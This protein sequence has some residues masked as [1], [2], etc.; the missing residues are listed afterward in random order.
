MKRLKRN[1]GM[2]KRHV[3]IINRKEI[4]GA[5]NRYITDKLFESRILE[6]PQQAMQR[7]SLTPDIPLSSGKK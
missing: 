2:K 4:S 3:T 6:L 5:L 1:S 7:M